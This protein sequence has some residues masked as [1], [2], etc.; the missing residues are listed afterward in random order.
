VNEV[1]GVV[2]FDTFKITVNINHILTRGFHKS[3]NVL[4]THRDYD[5]F[6][7]RSLCSHANT[8]FESTEIVDSFVDFFYFL[9]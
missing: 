4:I 2:G 6:I 3:S 9:I 1:N 5:L 7:Q 8:R